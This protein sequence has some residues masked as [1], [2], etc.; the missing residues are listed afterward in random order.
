MADNLFS[1]GDILPFIAPADVVDLAWFATKKYVFDC[2]AMVLY[3][4]PI[5]ALASIP[6][7]R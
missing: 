1:H 4:Q 7:E 5:A 6:I 2:R 3:C